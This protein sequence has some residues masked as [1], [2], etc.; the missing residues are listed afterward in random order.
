MVR[1]NE[2]IFGYHLRI[3][4]FQEAF[5]PCKSFFS[6]RFDKSWGHHVTINPGVTQFE[7]VRVNDPFDFVEIVGGNSRCKI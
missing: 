5:D 1:I 7:C 6:R 4:C 2:F 3:D